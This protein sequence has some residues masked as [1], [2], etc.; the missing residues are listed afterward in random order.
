[1][2]QQHFIDGDIK[3]RE[4]R[5]GFD[6]GR[7]SLLMVHGSGGTGLNWR[8]Q[9][10]GLEAANPAAVDLPGHGET[11]GPGLE[12]VEDYADWLAGL[13]AAGPV[14]PVVMG[15]SL[16]GAI[17]QV[18]ALRRPELI[19][20]L[21]LVGTGSRLRVL[22]AILEGLRTQPEQTVESIIGYAYGDDPDPALV[23]RGRRE[24]LEV[25]PGVIL[26]DFAACDAFDAT[27]RLGEIAAPTCV[28][29]G[30]EDKLTPPKYSAFL[31]ERIPHAGEPVVIP[32]GGHMIYIEEPAAFNQA[33]SGFLAGL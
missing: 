12:R 10:S 4:G 26:G 27:D 29:V 9:L 5:A 17:A 3:L 18:L 23:E 6:P 22:P 28:I 24:M 33:V 25:D 20:G 21:I 15:H 8:P 32:G 16:G 1:M 14:R 31:A 11:P 13:I 30:A 2:W 19:H 7:P